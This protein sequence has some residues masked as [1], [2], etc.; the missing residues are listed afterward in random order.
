MPWIVG[1]WPGSITM[2]DRLAG[3]TVVREGRG[4]ACA[5]VVVRITLGGEWLAECVGGTVDDAELAAGLSGVLD[6]TVGL[7]AGVRAALHPVTDAITH[8]TPRA[9]AA[10]RRRSR[11]SIP[12]P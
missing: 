8:S 4:A 6:T 5:R 2:T 10:E 1:L 9:R 7:G 3:G 12:L 11:R